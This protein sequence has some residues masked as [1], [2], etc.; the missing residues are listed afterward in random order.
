MMAT[1]ILIFSCAI[2]ASSA[3]V[4]WNPPSPATTHTSLSGTASF[5]PMAA[6]S[7]N[8]MVPSPPE[9]ISVRGSS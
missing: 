5:A 6:G 7:A 4:I 2:V 3:I 1:L 9:V 8:P